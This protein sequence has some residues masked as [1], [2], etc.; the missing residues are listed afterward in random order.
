MRGKELMT[1]F[2]VG[3]FVDVGLTNIGL[4]IAGFKEVGLVAS[5]IVES[6]HLNS[7]V[8]LRSG[9]TAV[10][11]GLYAL[12]KDHGTRF[13]FSFEKALQYSNYIVWGINALNAAQIIYERLPKG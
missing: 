11:I 5:N 7:A 13:A 3:N 10:L 8:L 6:G 9:V 1:S 12:N 4:N 2:M